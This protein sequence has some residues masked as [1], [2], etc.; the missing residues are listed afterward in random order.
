MNINVIKRSWTEVPFDKTGIKLVIL[1]ANREVP[2]PERMSDHLVNDITASVV[3]NCI[4]LNSSVGVEEIQN[5]VVNELMGYNLFDIA[6]K[7][8]TYRYNRALARQS[9]TTNEQI[10]SLI[11]YVNKEVKQENSNK[12]PIVNSI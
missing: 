9:N 10:L 8:I 4:S 7:Y 2:E 6:R 11:E 5:M 1:K 12:N 3:K